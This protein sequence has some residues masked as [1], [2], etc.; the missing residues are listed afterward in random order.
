MLESMPNHHDIFEALQRRDAKSA[1]KSIAADI[2]D[3][4]ECL[5]GVLKP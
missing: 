1:R 3:C 2:S 5:R 4:A